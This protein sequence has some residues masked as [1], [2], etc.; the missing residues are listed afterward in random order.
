MYII[1]KI[2]ARTQSNGSNPAFEALLKYY[3]C[4][5]ENL[6]WAAI[7]TIESVT[8][9]S[10]DFIRR[11]ILVYLSS[12]SNF[13]LRASAASICWSLQTLIRPVFQSTFYFHF[14]HMTKIGTYRP[15][16]MPR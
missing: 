9:L 14:R 12:H 8:A 11:N 2:I 4:P 3:V 7:Q 16:P 10:P 5:S 15:R 1:P 6:Q 13:S